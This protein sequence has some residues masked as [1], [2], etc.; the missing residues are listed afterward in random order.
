M[1]MQDLIC[2]QRFHTVIFLQKPLNF[3]N[4]LMAK[5]LQAFFS[6]SGKRFIILTTDLVSRQDD[7]IRTWNEFESKS[8]NDFLGFPSTQNPIHFLMNSMLT[9]N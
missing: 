2:F 6:V 1:S 3:N 7:Y 5:Q 4:K 9:H 8:A